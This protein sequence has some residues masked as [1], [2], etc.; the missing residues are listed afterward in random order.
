MKAILL[1]N[2]LGISF[3]STNADL[4]AAADNFKSV[5]SHGIIDGYIGC[6]DGILLKFKPLH[7]KK[8]ET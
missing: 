3:P 2:E 8:L 6:L 7:Q 4:Q 1:C 5:S